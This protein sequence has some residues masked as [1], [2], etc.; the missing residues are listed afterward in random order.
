MAIHGD[1]LLEAW[2]DPGNRGRYKHQKEPKRTEKDR[3]VTEKEPKRTEKDRK[4]RNHVLFTKKEEK[5]S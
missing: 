4:A 3:K 2:M 5:C 1:L